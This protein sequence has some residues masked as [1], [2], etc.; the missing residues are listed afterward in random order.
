M[1]LSEKNIVIDR[2]KYQLT[3][4]Y[5]LQLVSMPMMH[6]WIIAKKMHLEKIRSTVWQRE[7]AQIQS[8]LTSVTAKSQIRMVSSITIQLWRK[9]A[10]KFHTYHVKE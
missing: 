1:S 10:G 6:T 3:K 7:G 2:Y 8:K 4:C 9:L 5:D